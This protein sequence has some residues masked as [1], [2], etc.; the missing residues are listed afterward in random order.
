VSKH[1][2][3]ELPHPAAPARKVPPRAQV[4]APTR[5]RLRC[6]H[7]ARGCRARHSRADAA[8]HCSHARRQVRSRLAAGG[9]AG[10]GAGVRRGQRPLRQGLHLQRRGDRAPGSQ[11]RLPRRAVRRQA[12]QRVRLL[13]L[14][15]AVAD[16][17]G[18]PGHHRARDVRA[19]HEGPGEAGA[20]RRAADPCLPVAPRVRPPQPGARPARR[21]DGLPDDAARHPR[22]LRRQPGLP[23]AGP[24][25]EHAARPARTRGRLRPGRQHLLRGLARLP[26]AHRR[27]PEQPARAAQPLG[28]PGLQPPRRLPQRRRQHPLH[29]RVGRVQGPDRARRDA[30]PEAG[31]QPVR[32][33]DQPG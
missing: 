24:S 32:A 16:E 1:V 10:A 8:Q 22:R 27:R 3:N 5:R 21:R 14:D 33:G 7:R 26:H 11:R 13:R 23:Q 2:R 18:G 6:G 15:A 20:H 12:G 9:D 4:L 25:V 29:G 17:R 28:E 31:V 19:G 30:G